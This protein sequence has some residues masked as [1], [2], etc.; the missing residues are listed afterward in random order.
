MT[1]TNEQNKFH[2]EQEACYICNE[3]FCM[4][5]TDEIY[6]NRRKVKDHCHYTGKFVGAARSICNLRYKVPENIPIVIHNA[7]YDTHF[8]I[9]QLAE[10]FKN[11][12]N[13]IGKDLEKYITFSAP[14]MKKM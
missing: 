4:D 14:I 1:L 11:E 5:K 9:N 10:E 8:I 13:C 6:E 3:K 7:S 12:L 2:E